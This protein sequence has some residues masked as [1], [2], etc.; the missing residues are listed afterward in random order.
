MLI[1]L[2]YLIGVIIHLLIINPNSLEK[3]LNKIKEQNI[4]YLD[5]GWR[6]TDKEIF[7]ACLL[8]PIILLLIILKKIT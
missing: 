5:N 1:L 7:M 6:P 8:W 2:I 4:N 3:E